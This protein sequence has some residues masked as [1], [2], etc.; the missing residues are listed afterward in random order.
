MAE[1]SYAQAE[2]SFREGLREEDAYKVSSAISSAR[3]LL[4]LALLVRGQASEAMEVFGPYLDQTQSANLMGH[5]LRDNPIVIPLLRHAHQRKMQRSYIEQVLEL[6]GAPLNAVEASGGEVLSERELEV[7]RVMAEGLSNR[8]IAARL[9][10]SEATVKTHVQRVM[11]K[12]DAGSRTQAV[13]R[14]L[15]LLLL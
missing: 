3:V 6:L 12:L 10:I 4:A 1:R 14:A 9:F 11:R 2:Q 13:A 5:L 7:L 8:E 15:E